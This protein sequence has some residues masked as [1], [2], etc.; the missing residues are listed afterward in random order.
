VHWLFGQQAVPGDPQATQRLLLQIAFA[1]LQVVAPPVVLAQQAEPSSPHLAQVPALHV[2]PAEVHTPVAG[3]LPQQGIPAAP[4]LPQAPALQT[5]P[6]P[7]QVPPSV[8]QIP[9]TQQPPPLQLFPS[10]HCVPGW[11]QAGTRLASALVP[12]APPWPTLLPVP[13]GGVITPPLP[14]GLAASAPLLDPPQPWTSMMAMLATT[15]IG[16]AAKRLVMIELIKS[17]ARV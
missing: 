9:E 2:V 5:P 16:K 6:T 11:P 15:N 4:Q 3:L 1:A 12:P 8:M 7:T 17:S 13:V 10:Q 14:V